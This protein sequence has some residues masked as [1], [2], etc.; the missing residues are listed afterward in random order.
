MKVKIVSYH[1][2]VIT[3]AVVGES[4][5]VSVDVTIVDTIGVGWAICVGEF[6]PLA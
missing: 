3:V 5:A 4:G 2:G 6:I 1:V